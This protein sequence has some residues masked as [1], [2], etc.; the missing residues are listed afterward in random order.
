[1]TEQPA[2]SSTMGWAIGPEVV[3]GA[4]EIVASVADGAG[5][6]LRQDLSCKIVFAAAGELASGR[7]RQ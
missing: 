7:D 1:M 2:R 3:A 4:V 6:H 5:G